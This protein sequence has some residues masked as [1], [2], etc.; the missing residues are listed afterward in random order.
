MLKI[1]LEKLE[2]IESILNEQQKQPLTL[3]E[4]S[5]FLNVSKS[6]LYKMTCQNK[7]PYYQPNGKK[8]YFKKSELEEWIFKHRV[9]THEDIEREAE[10]YIRKHPYNPLINKRRK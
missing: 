6:Y 1:I 7:L 10:E 8:I 3:N 9:K 2:K 4:A 5:E